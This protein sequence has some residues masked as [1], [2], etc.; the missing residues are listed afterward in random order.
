MNFARLPE[1]FGRMFF[2]EHGKG[3]SLLKEDAI[4]GEIQRFSTGFS[5]FLRREHALSFAS[6]IEKLPL[7][8]F[9][10]LKYS[11]LHAPCQRQTGERGAA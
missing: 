3:G 7:P 6:F 10:C 4:L 1:H 2:I 8:M 5:T 11:E 9:A